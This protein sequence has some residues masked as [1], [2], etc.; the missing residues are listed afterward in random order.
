MF[1]R[2]IRA[3]LIAFVMLTPAWSV[4]AQ[5]TMPAPPNPAARLLVNG[6]AVDGS[7]LDVLLMEQ[8]GQGRADNTPLRGA[9]REDLIR[10]ELL[11][12]AARKAGIDKQPLASTQASLAFDAVLTRAYVQQWLTQ[13]P[14]K[15]DAIKLEYEA[16]KTRM[17]TQELQLRQ[18]VVATEAEAK[19]TLARL[20]KGEKF[21]DIAAATSR[22]PSSRTNGGLLAWAPLGA[23]NPNVLEAVRAM[24]KGQLASAPVSTPAGWHVFRVEAV[25]PFTP[26]ALSAMQGQIRQALER[27]AVDVYVTNLRQQAKVE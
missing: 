14:I 5:S 3:A 24:T 11:L 10:L 6:Q 7:R 18:V 8:L 9:V 20:T 19:A 26:P 25:R 13:N 23:L 16:W 1:I 12:Q 21:E 4:L 17:G 2:T 15:E 22:D 27:K